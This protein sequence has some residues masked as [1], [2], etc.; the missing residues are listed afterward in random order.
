M[1]T[2]LH[3]EDLN[4]D[5][6]ANETNKALQCTKITGGITNALICVSGFQSLIT[7]QSANHEHLSQSGSN[8][9]TSLTKLIHYDEDRISILCSKN[10][11]IVFIFIV[12][13]VED[14]TGG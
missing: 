8:T 12:C 4:W 10:Q 2:L 9:T 7:S 14:G 1:F 11:G 13:R 6:L 5:A 3:C